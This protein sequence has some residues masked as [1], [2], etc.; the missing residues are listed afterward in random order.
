MYIFNQMVDNQKPTKQ[1]TLDKVFHA[2]A[3]PSRR[4][5]LALLRETQELSVG[6]LAAAFDISLN[7]VSKHIKVLER[8]SLVQRR[9]DGRVHY[10][11]VNWHAL[12]PAYGFLHFYQ[13]FWNQRLDKLVDYISQEPTTTEKKN[14]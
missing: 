12:Q 10:L 6:D 1:D 5:L 13:H 9:V 8:A 2:L 3:D 14:K 7:G 11:R 4:K